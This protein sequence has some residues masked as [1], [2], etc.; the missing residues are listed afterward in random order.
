MFRGELLVVSLYHVQ[1]L[2]IN[3]V[4]CELVTILLCYSKFL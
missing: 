3:S 4:E 2:Q 1:T